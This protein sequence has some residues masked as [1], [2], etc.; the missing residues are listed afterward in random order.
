[1]Q[2]AP[3]HSKHRLCTLNKSNFTQ[4]CQQDGEAS[5]TSENVFIV[6]VE[7]VNLNKKK[8][9]FLLS[10]NQ[11]KLLDVFE[12]PFLF[13]IKFECGINNSSVIEVK[14]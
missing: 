6:L 14:K 8:I 11:N 3:L 4:A 2:N 10:Q 1:M 13:T 5:D 12:H 7:Q 9:F